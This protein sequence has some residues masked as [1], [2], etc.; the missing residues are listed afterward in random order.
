MTAANS[1]GDHAALFQLDACVFKET[2]LAS[3]YT[4]HADETAVLTV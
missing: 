3:A 1:G 4:L 2:R